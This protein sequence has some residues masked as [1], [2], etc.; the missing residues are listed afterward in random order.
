MV[1]V[2]SDTA[3][4]PRIKVE[5]VVV[6]YLPVLLDVA[7]FAAAVIGTWFLFGAWAWITAAALLILA[8]IEFGK[9]E[10]RD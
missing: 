7:G 10:P 5:R 3:S 4:L 1:A 6:K 9:P 8:G 2:A